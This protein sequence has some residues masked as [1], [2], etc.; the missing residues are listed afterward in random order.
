MLL[1]ATQ[2]WSETVI[3]SKGKIEKRKKT[4]KITGYSENK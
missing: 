4:D 3:A 1:Q 2:E